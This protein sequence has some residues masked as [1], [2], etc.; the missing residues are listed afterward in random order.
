MIGGGKSPIFGVALISGFIP[1]LNL[2]SIIQNVI[3]T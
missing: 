3:F 1:K 2:K